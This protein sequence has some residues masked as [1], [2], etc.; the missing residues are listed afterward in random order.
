MVAVARTAE[1]G[2]VVLAW[3]VVSCLVLVACGAA[4]PPP[5]PARTTV[6]TAPP[7][8][9]STATSTAPS[10]DPAAG[11]EQLVGV[12]SHTSTYSESVLRFLPDG[13]YAAVQILSRPAANGVFQAT[14]AHDGRAEVDGDRLTLRPARATLSIEDDDDP[15]SSYTD[16]PSST[17]PIT[18]RWRI[19]DGVLTLTGDTGATPYRREQ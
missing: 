13:R 2:A 11:P 10:T 19:D 17:D 16:R 12:W 18:Y 9:T 4:E 3:V 6:V 15:A 8:A 14:F 7:T 1:R 5:G